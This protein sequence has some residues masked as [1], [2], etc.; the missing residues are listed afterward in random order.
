MPWEVLTGF[1]TAPGSTLTALTMGSGDSLTVRKSEKPKLLTPWADDQTTAGA[2]RIRSVLMHDAVQGLR[3]QGAVDELKPLL[4]IGLFQ[5]L[6]PQD[7]LTV[8]I[9]GS[10]VAGDIETAVLPIHYEDRK[11]TRLNSSHSQISYAVFC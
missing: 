8:E 5:P 4:P 3:L 1:A 6:Q 2:L 7:V 10:A 11:S 9:S